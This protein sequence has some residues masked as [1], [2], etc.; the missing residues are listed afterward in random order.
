MTR[1]QRAK[2]TF[3]SNSLEATG[4]CRLLTPYNAAVPPRYAFWTILIDQKP[5]A[6]RAAQQ[7]DLL[8]TLHQ[9]RRTN[10]DVVLKWFARGKL[11]ESPDAERAAQRKPK[12]TPKRG[13]DW[14]PG[15]THQDPR[16]RF[17]KARR[18]EQRESTVPQ[19]HRQGRR[20]RRK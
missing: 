8:P 1:D 7:E 20:D 11:W 16:A 19:E 17:S 15:G 14:R 3:L 2:A 5:T 6:F 18:R 12:L 13:P 10:K 4:D 9:L